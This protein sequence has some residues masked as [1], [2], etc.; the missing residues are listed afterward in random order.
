M[1]KYSAVTLVRFH[2]SLSLSLLTSPVKIDDFDKFRFTTECLCPIIESNFNLSKPVNYASILALDRKV[3]EFTHVDC[4]NV[5][6]GEGKTL[7][8]EMQTHVSGYVKEHGT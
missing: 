3:R 5:M 7:G 8:M 6:S 1:G 2:S 4:A